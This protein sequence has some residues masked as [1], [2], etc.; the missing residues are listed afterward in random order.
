MNNNVFETAQKQIQNAYKIANFWDIY[1]NELEIILNPKRVLETSLAVEMDD[2]TIK[3]FTAYRSQH[4]DARWPFK[5]G[6]RF[7]PDVNKDEVKALSMWMT[8][9]CSVVDIPLGGGKWGIIVD[10][11]NLSEKEIEKLSREY[12]R[13]IYKDIWPLV[14]VPAPDVNTNPKIMGFMVDEYSKQ[15][16]IYSP[17]SFTGKPLSAGGSK[18]REKATW[19]GWVYTLKKYLE[20]DGQTL[21]DKK[22]IVEWAWNVAL[23]FVEIL[24]NDWVKLVWISDSR[25]GI[26]DENGLDIEKIVSLKNEGKSVT[27]YENVEKVSAD[28]LLEKNCDILVPAAL[29]NRIT[30]KNAGKIQ[31]KL[32]LE[33]ANW[34]TTPEADEILNERNISLIPDI[35]ANAGWVM[36]SYFEQVQ[37]NTNFYWEEDEVEQKLKTKMERAAT[38]VYNISKNLNSSFRAW[39]YSIAL[40][41]VFEAMKVRNYR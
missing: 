6:I 27:A 32:V 10:P 28:E 16:W 3:T 5:G 19:Q 38:D 36:V 2:G 37:N 1:K 25:G 17:G 13:A 34:P 8:I 29:E 18:W 22:I 11:K 20:L 39:A 26:Y 35:L 7:H 4:N 9:K 41:R 24:K 30:E 15:V 31:A 23:H 14:D 33:L 40:K 12:V 21:K